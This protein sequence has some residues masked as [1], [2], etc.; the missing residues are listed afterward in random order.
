MTYTD[1]EYRVLDARAKSLRKELESM[2]RQNVSLRNQLRRIAPYADKFDREF[3]EHQ[4]A[5]QIIADQSAQI[6]A[7]LKRLQN[8]G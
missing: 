3:I 1:V 5:K 8:L 7:L 4:E 2:M 6:S